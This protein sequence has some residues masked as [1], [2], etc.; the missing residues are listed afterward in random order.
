MCSGGEGKQ[1]SCGK[2]G[3][4]SLQKV[5]S[6]V[7]D[8]SEPC[9]SQSRI[10]V[11]ITIGKMLKPEKWQAS[12]D[13]DGRVSGFQKALKLIILGGIDPSIRAEV[14]EFLL[15]C[16]AL[17]STSEY[18]NQLRVA[19]RKRY[20]DLLKQCQT[21]HS[22]VGTG[23]LAYV[24]GSKVM[25]MRKSY[26]D[27][28]VKVATTDENRE[29]AFIDNNDN[30]N[31][32]NHHSDWS[33]NGTDTSHL[34]RRGSSSESVDLVSGR[35]S[36]E[37]VV[38]NTSSFVSASSPYGY[39][40]P[41]GYF[42]FPSLPVTDLFGRNSLD[43]IEVSTPDED[44]SLKS[45]LRSEDE[46]MH[47]FRID[48]NADLIREQRRSTPEIKVMHS[49]SVGPSSYTGRNAEI[50]DGLRISDVPEMASVKD[51]P[52]R[53][54][55]VTEDRVS[56][57]LWTLHRIVVDVVRTDSH[58]EFYED[59]GN[60]G[61]MS[62]ILAVYAWVDPATGYCQGMSD[63]VS[64]FVVLFEDN[65]DAFWCFEMLI[66]RTRA[67]FQMEGPTGV[68]DQLQSLWHILQI[69]DKDIFSHLSRIGAES[70]HFAFRMLLVLFRRELSFNEALRMWEMMWAADYDESVTETLENDCLEPLVIQ[71]PRKSEPEVSEEMIEDGIG[72][73]TK[74]E[75][76]ISKSGPISKSS[77]LLSRSGLLPKS[78]PLPKTA[79]PFSDESEIKSASSSYHFCGL[80]RSLWSRNDRTT[81]VPCV[82]SSIK[83]GDDA[84]PV[85]CVA[86]ILIMNR[87]KIMKE[88]RS[89]DDMI[90]IF[91]DKVLVFRVRRCIRTA[92]KLRRKYMY[93]SQVIKTKSHT[94]SQNLNQVH[95]QHQTHMES[96]RP[97][98][99]Q[100]HGENQSQTPSFHHSPATQ[101]GD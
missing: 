55:N 60:L 57:W 24:V 47:N 83:K 41:D 91:N 12:F 10:Q 46:G 100:S 38:Y 79:G 27:E 50:V 11:V 29:D 101:N 1:W 19:R 52:S 54:G 63:L 90:Q 65:A 30:A 99:I 14:W 58:L 6:L 85:F 59:P 77:G 8:L 36:P 73:S 17:S 13:S 25:D 75:P 80:T 81:H 84:L 93:K 23:S 72:N 69:T 95:I 64:P 18:R 37:S 34:H 16:Y 9:L 28:A 21:M 2:A 86:A 7:R 35:E 70:L 78:G 42:D 94:Q 68:M 44:A 62:D 76:M 31:T 89:I 5:G 67:N 39:A 40:S 33:N 22:S 49:D 74:R 98:E 15:G 4:V 88:T 61:R 43:K 51:T 56:E 20:N 97:E 66:R 45:E 71:L 3:V 96:Q 53:V 82:V 48:K 87:H 26:R 32:E 92:M